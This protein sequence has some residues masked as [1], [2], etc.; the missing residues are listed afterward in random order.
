MD[1]EIVILAENL[2]VCRYF[3]RETLGLGEPVA[4]SAFQVIFALNPHTRLVLE[5]CPLPYL[6]HLSS[7][8]RFTIVADDLTKCISRLEKNAVAVNEGFDSSGCKV[9]YAVDPEGNVFQLR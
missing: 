4:D 8:C 9:Y 3:Y 6:E 2:D 1:C 7:A 5:K